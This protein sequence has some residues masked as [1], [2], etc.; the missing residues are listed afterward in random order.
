MRTLLIIGFGSLLTLGGCPSQTDTTS[1]VTAVMGISATQGSAPLTIAVSAVDSTSTNAGDLAYYW[2]FGG[3]A[4]ATTVNATHTFTTPGRYRVALRVTD[5]N[6]E[7]DTTGEDVSVA[8]EY[9]PIAIIQASSN[10]GYVGLAVQFDGSESY[11]E[12]DTIYNYSW[13]FGDGGTSQ[14]VK[15]AHVFDREGSF[16]VTLTVTTSGGRSA[17]TTTT[18][19]VGAANGSL[20]FNGSQYATLLTSDDTL[21]ALTFEAWIK[22]D[23]SGGSIVSVGN[24]ALQIEVRPSD[25]LVR[26]QVAGELHEA[27]V[28]NLTGQWRHIALTYDTADNTR[29]YVDG[30]A[31]TTA[32]ATEAVNITQLTL[33]PSYAGKISDVRYWS[34]ARTAAE[35]LARMNLRLAGSETG[36]LGYWKLDEGYGQTLLNAVGESGYLGAQIGTELSD[37]AWSTDGPQLD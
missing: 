13:N 4:T 11:A 12:D 31:I 36:L 27:S 25:N 19:L 26:F 10:S 20:Q 3:E 18:I 2:D 9:D 7:T 14:V 30:A 17:S 15:P 5:A 28:S 35:I 8:G 32:D 22:A 29:L 23:S 34:V 37:P 33:G 16:T 24:G 1:A 21:D 6:D